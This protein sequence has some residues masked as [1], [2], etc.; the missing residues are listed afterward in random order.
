[1]FPELQEQLGIL[2]SKEEKLIKILDFAQIE[3][4]VTV[5]KITNPPKDILIPSLLNYDTNGGYS[6]LFLR[7]GISIS[8]FRKYSLLTISYT[9]KY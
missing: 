2:S 9:Y 3:N 7:E 1:M 6:C 5:V 8:G 4:N